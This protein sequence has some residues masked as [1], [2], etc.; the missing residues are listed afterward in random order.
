MSEDD[1]YTPIDVDMLRM[2]N[3]LLSFE[4]RFL[5][6]RLG[7]SAYGL[8][9]STPLSRISYLAEAKGDLVLL[10]ERLGNSPLGTPFRLKREFRVLENRYLRSAEPLGPPTSPAHIA[11]LEG[12]EKD[13][14]LLLTRLG[15]PPFS[16]LLG[17]R[18]SFQ[19]LQERYLSDG[20]GA[21]SNG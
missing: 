10:L 17:R 18:K 3:E 20:H 21:N 9:A 13:L 4:V 15:R 2:E 8:G 16:W 7:W 1:F 19:T 14:I 6:A 11:H 5:K 12:A